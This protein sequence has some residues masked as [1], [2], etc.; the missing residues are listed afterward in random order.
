MG[1]IKLNG[2][3]HTY[4]P[5]PPY[6]S[7]AAAP[8]RSLAL[9]G[10]VCAALSLQPSGDAKEQ[11]PPLLRLLSLL[12]AQCLTHPFGFF[13]LRLTLPLTSSHT[14]GGRRMTAAGLKPHVPVLKLKA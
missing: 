12:F 11:L 13:L 4:I 9:A 7:Q 5:A 8:R 14:R 3:G 2:F 10:E 1:V 6:L